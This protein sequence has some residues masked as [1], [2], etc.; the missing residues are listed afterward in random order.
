MR[1]RA[2]YSKSSKQFLPNFCAVGC[3]CSC[4]SLRLFTKIKLFNFESQLRKHY[5]ITHS[6]LCLLYRAFKKQ[7]LYCGVC[8]YCSRGN[9]LLQSLCLPFKEREE[10]RGLAES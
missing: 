7:M 3:C 4:I 9:I 8:W 1:N 2:C 6:F 5:L 10:E